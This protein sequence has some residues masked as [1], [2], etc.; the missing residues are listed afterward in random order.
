NRG[1]AV[2][3]SSGQIQTNTQSVVLSHTM[4]TVQGDEFSCLLD[5]NDG[6][7]SGAT[8]HSATVVVSAPTNTA[9]TLT[10]FSI[11]PSSPKIGGTVA[12]SATLH[13]SEQQAVGYV[14]KLLVNGVPGLESSG[15][16]PIDTSTLVLS[17]APPA[18]LPGDKLQC[19]LD[20][21]DGSIAGN[22]SPVFTPEV[23]VS[24][25][26]TPG[27]CGVPGY[28]AGTC[29]GSNTGNT[30]GS[31][32]Y[33]NP[34]GKACCE[35]VSNCA[36]VNGLCT[37]TAGGATHTVLCGEFNSNEYG[38][39]SFA[40][41]A[42]MWVPSA[43]G[44]SACGEKIPGSG[45]CTGGSQP[46][47]DCGALSGAGQAC[48]EAASCAWSNSACQYGTAT[49]SVFCQNYND[50]KIACESFDNPASGCTWSSCGT[51]VPNSGWCTAKAASTMQCN[52]ITNQ[53]CCSKPGSGCTW[54]GNSCQGG[55]VSTGICQNF[56]DNYA[57]CNNFHSACTWGTSQ[58]SSAGG[59]CEAPY[60]C[61]ENQDLTCGKTSI[62]TGA[63]SCCMA[64]DAKGCIFN[65]QCCSGICTHHA[66]QAAACDIAPTISSYTDITLDPKNS[67]MSVFVYSLDRVD[68]IKTPMPDALIFMVNLT[69]KDN[70]NMCY[71]KTGSDGRLPYFYDPQFPGCLDYWFIFCPLS[72][73]AG[74]DAAAIKARE[75]CLGSTG[76]SP[77]TLSQAPIPCLDAPA[78]TGIKNYPDY[79]LSH[80]ELYI[81]NKVP[82]DFAPLCWPL[83][84]IL[85]LLLG[86][87]F[88][89]GRNPFQMFDMSSPRL[90]RGRQYSARVQNK[91]FDLISYAMGTASGTMAV[92]SDMQ[93]IKAGGVMGPIKGA[94]GLDMQ[95]KEKGKGA[96]LEGQSLEN[97][98]P[99]G[100]KKVGGADGGDKGG[101]TAT[102]GNS[103][104]GAQVNKAVQGSG[105]TPVG[106]NAKQAQASLKTVAPSKETK[107]AGGE[108]ADAGRG[109]VGAAPGS[110]Q[111]GV[112]Q[113]IAFQGLS[114]INPVSSII[115]AFTNKPT[116]ENASSIDK[117][118][119]GFSL[120]GQ[121]VGQSI[122]E[123]LKLLL[124]ISL[125]QYG[126]SKKDGQP[127]TDAIKE[128]FTKGSWSD[129]KTSVQ[130]LLDLVKLM[131]ALYS[132]MCEISN[133]S[134]ALQ[135]SGKGDK[136][137]G[138][139]DSFNSSGAFKIGSYGMNV[140][141]I[142]G[143]L[144][145]GLQRVGTSYDMANAGTAPGVPYPFN[146]LVSPVLDGL[147]LGVGAV[148][149]AIDAA[150]DRK[151]YGKGEGAPREVVVNGDATLG[152]AAGPGNTKIYY[153]PASKGGKT[154]WAEVDALSLTD[155][156][157]KGLI[158]AI[159]GSPAQYLK[160]NGYML[161]DGE[162]M[163]HQNR[164]ASVSEARAEAGMYLLKSFGSVFGQDKKDA[165]GA[166]ISAHKAYADMLRKQNA[167]AQSLR[168]AQSYVNT[169]RDLMGKINS[170]ETVHN[171]IEMAD[172]KT[173]NAEA[174]K[175]AEAESS[176][177]KAAAEARKGKLEESLQSLTPGSHAY[178][179]AKGEITEIESAISLC[180]VLEAID[181]PFDK[182]Q[183]KATNAAMQGYFA[184]QL[185]AT[186]TFS[187]E[188]FGARS[189]AAQEA[190][191]STF[192]TFTKG[193][194]DFET[195][196]VKD[197]GALNDKV[198]VMNAQLQAAKE[199]LL[200]I[201]GVNDPA[202][203]R[204]IADS[205]QKLMNETGARVKAEAAEKDR[206]AAA[207]RKGAGAPDFA[208]GASLQ[209]GMRDFAAKEFK[210]DS[211]ANAAHADAVES[212]Q[213]AQVGE[214]R[215][216]VG[217]YTEVAKGMGS[218]TLKKEGEA[219]SAARVLNVD[220]ADNYANIVAQ[221]A[222]AFPK[223]LEQTE[224]RQLPALE[225]II[226][227]GARPKGISEIDLKKIEDD[228][229]AFKANKTYDNIQ[230]ISDDYEATLKSKRSNQSSPLNDETPANTSGVI[231]DKS[232]PSRK[233]G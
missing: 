48:C 111:S 8:A 92:K 5:Y 205:L 45:S 73:A 116:A 89:V 164:L 11:S 203:L 88:A 4:N 220:A 6:Y 57:A 36:W 142:A 180:R 22:P 46:I 26:S 221:A 79:I 91:N 14:A 189:P 213:E 166:N 136:A 178:N 2:W 50:N 154:V 18:L 118:I 128:L 90:A 84:L 71:S 143:W 196:N 61:C 157:K 223:I 171:A 98:K 158:A 217:F 32:T 135:V 147:G 225:K 191:A 161:D 216:K 204:Q 168:L 146:Y 144:D 74:Q 172:I 80:N 40:S 97:V 59:S 42:C 19:E 110:S 113:G 140:N 230:L 138:F 3:Q 51:V 126:I 199:G 179:S 81:C 47:G 148:A 25:G 151:A 170:N 102:G 67:A 112:S 182:R 141:A 152:I 76:L 70:I 232:T 226:K 69:D 106:K 83:M 137:K 10:S 120:K 165:I 15:S 114:G 82:R 133:Y 103:G 183:L 193:F 229:E 38:C 177:R 207:G 192:E 123:I 78:P 93:G 63:K 212:L 198:E 21:T 77:A 31:C 210:S 211:A 156:Q 228:V 17:V 200:S 30:V 28:G 7:L 44:P 62:Y 174:D 206:K 16:M 233:K 139:M 37:S 227:S 124:N 49:P 231:A 24:S 68:Y 86:A 54:N 129:V 27:E 85:G 121:N 160:K 87:S 108:K 201:S 105:G 145:P 72:A 134:K 60:L 163:D 65:S 224:T 95:K 215:A 64:N 209:G 153:A 155:A 202:A 184:L 33:M 150:V 43:P 96:A 167:S 29:A 195:G 117:L 181:S 131:I 39:K 107:R 169:T 222:A 109:N 197:I 1:V 100:A 219:L 132:I 52:G 101:G 176:A 94:L 53:A 104:Q 186:T 9:P 115:K 185:D 218:S 34:E 12:C 173:G 58:C 190:V 214:A 130:T 208:E 149:S 23:T 162:R 187:N 99:G 41:A 66:C 35:K 122:L 56:N 119:V 125:A 159:P 13:D 188:Y 194:K 55:L 75:T 20:Y 175:K 127:S